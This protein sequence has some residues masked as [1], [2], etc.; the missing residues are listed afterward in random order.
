MTRSDINNWI[1]S[2]LFVKREKDEF[3][4][5]GH[6]IQFEN[7]DSYS[8]TYIFDSSI[9]ISIIRINHKIENIMIDQS[10]GCGNYKHISETSF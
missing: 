4:E 5:D 9:R 2:H 1:K 3:T 7:G 10:I 8:Y 6:Y